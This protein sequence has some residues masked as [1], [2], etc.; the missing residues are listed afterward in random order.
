MFDMHAELSATNELLRD[1]ATSMRTIAQ[2]LHRLAPDVPDVQA[3]PATLKDLYT[4]TPEVLSE[5]EESEN[6]F[7]RLSNTIR[8]SE[9]YNTAKVAYEAEFAARFGT[10][11]VSALPWNV[12]RRKGQA[13]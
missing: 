8:G 7:A 4:P 5:I 13:G 6:E 11:A 9:A 3:I 1:I 10:E 12:A 2:C